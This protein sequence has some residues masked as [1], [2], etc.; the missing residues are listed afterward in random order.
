MLD[1][2]INLLKLMKPI[3]WRNTI[4]F[5]NGL[6]EDIQKTLLLAAPEAIRIAK[7]ISPYFRRDTDIKSL[8]AI[9]TFIR[10][11][12]GYRKD[13]K[14][15]QQIKMP[16]RFILESGDCKSNAL[17]IYAIAKNLGI[18]IEFKFTNYHTYQGA[19]PSHVYNVAYL[20]NLNNFVFID[21][22]S[23]KFNIE[24]KPNFSKVSK[25]MK[26]Q[27]LSDNISGKTANK[28]AQK[29]AA[30]APAT[31]SRKAKARKTV[32]N[33]KKQIKKVTK[34]AVSVGKKTGFV[35]M[36]SA[37]LALLA[38]N[39]RGLATNTKIALEKNPQKVENLWVKT[40]GGSLSSLRQVVIKGAKKKALLGL[41]K[42]PD[43]IA[44]ITAAS[45]GAAIATASPIIL[46]ISQLFKQSGVDGKMVID[47]VKKAAAAVK[48]KE[49]SQ[50]AP[51]Q[52]EKDSTDI[53]PDNDKGTMDKIKSIPTAAKLLAGA[54]ILYGG[55]KYM[56]PSSKRK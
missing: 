53:E 21:G 36:R 9:H 10:K 14:G 35:A 4:N 26:I 48:G 52:K 6:N 15:L 11:N 19:K 2:R 31:T 39:A 12:L 49:A 28:K 54:A 8:K 46:K 51:D 22:T 18:P 44:E 29:K 7:P 20:Q 1:S 32:G 27:T 33:V 43:T 37:F 55:Y 16:N 24:R 17:F 23:A 3:K 56:Q 5:N 34:K 38:V 45:I 50:Q 13:P 40:F 30:K 47:L 41:K 42:K 25:T